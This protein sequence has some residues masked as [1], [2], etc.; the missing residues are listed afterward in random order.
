MEALFVILLCI[1]AILIAAVAICVWLVVATGKAIFGLFSMARRPKP[2]LINPAVQT[3]SNAHCAC[4][5]PA[6][7]R[8]CRRCGKSLPSLLRLV[9]ERAAML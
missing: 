2:L 6:H 1:V 5:N 9:S 4:D 3:C 8:F 7:A